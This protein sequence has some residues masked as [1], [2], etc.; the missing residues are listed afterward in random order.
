[1]RWSCSR[2]TTEVCPFR[3]EDSTARGSNTLPCPDL[4]RIAIPESDSSDDT[5]EIAPS[6]PLFNDATT[7]LVDVN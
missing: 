7:H 6:T 4:T 2:K 1:M 3:G 5:R